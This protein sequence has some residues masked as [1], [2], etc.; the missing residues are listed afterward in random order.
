[1]M[2]AHASETFMP[3]AY[4]L[5]STQP[6][7]V[8]DEA[9]DVLDPSTDEIVDSPFWRIERPWSFEENMTRNAIMTKWRAGGLDSVSAVHTLIAFG[10]FDFQRMLELYDGYIMT[11]AKVEC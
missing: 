1:M 2:N 9:V 11:L 3:D 8:I 5:P 10:V 7:V 4:T 6:Q